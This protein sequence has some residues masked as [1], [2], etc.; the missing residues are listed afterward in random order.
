MVNILLSNLETQNYILKVPFLNQCIKIIVDFCYPEMILLFG[1]FA[2]G[3]AGLNSDLD[4]LILKKDLAKENERELTKQLYREFL[5]HDL[6]IAKDV[7][8]MNYER[9][10]KLYNVNGYIYNTVRE[11][12]IV[13]YETLY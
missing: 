5:N 7:M 4:L 12:G 11:E 9:Y 8:I 2:R 3:E 1:S 13:V 6:D 10:F